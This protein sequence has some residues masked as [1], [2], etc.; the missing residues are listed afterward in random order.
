MNRRTRHRSALA[1]LAA[2]WAALML[3]LLAQATGTP[4]SVVWI[5]VCTAQGMKPVPVAAADEPGAAPAGLSLHGM[6]D[7]CPWCLV[8]HEAALPSAS[9][10]ARLALAATARW[11][12][13]HRTAAPG[14][15]APFLQPPPRG[16]PAVAA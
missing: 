13:Q 2:M 9:R 1:V 6:L 8:G 10:A 7:H 15:P 14:R 16:P 12:P 4:G 3:P 5:E 11:V